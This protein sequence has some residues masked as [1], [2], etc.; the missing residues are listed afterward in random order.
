M[1]NFLKHR[2]IVAVACVLAACSDQTD[3]PLEA[4]AVN[5]IKLSG[6]SAANWQEEAR[7]QVVA[8]NLAKAG[9][10]ASS[11]SAERWPVRQPRF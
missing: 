8:H 5:A 11:C 4:P 2:I 6:S 9:S 7:M 3:S 10:V 1:S